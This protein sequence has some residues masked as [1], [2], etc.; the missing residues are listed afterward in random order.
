ME[1]NKNKKIYNVINIIVILIS[2]AILFTYTMLNIDAINIRLIALFL[3]IFVLINI[4]KFIR[5]YLI[6]LEEKIPITRFTKLYIKTTFVNILIPFKIGEIFRIYCFGKEIKNYYKGILGIILDRFVDSII[7]LIIIIPME[8]MY[9]HRISFVSILIIAYVLVILLF[10]V[11]TPS[12][13]KYL[14]KYIITNKSKKSSIKALEILEKIKM[15][16]KNGMELLRGRIPLLL[17][18]SSL[19]WILEYSLINLISKIEIGQF[20]FTVFSEY[21]NSAFL[22]NTNVVLINYFCM[23]S[24]VLGAVMLLVYLYTRCCK[25]V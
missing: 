9:L 1:M 12:T 17:I 23:S 16:H 5:L 19:A 25:K 6:F 10:L 24:I 7:L 14:N 4:I 15:V 2:F 22:T 21:L 3:T 11:F 8:I 20:E 13:Y 18:M